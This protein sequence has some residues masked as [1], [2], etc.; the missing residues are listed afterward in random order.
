MI[1]VSPW[2]VERSFFVFARAAVTWSF[3]YLHLGCDPPILLSDL[4]HVLHLIEGVLD[5][6]CAQN[7]L[8]RR[9]RFG[10]IDVDEPPVQRLDRCGVLL[11]EELEPVRLQTEERVQ[12]IEAPLVE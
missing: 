1:A 8:E 6:A 12:G 2:T 7:D 5:R 3:A 10:F 4:V 11:L 9:R